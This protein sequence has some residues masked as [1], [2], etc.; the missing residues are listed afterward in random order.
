MLTGMFQEQIRVSDEQPIPSFRKLEVQPPVM[1]MAPAVVVRLPNATIEVSNN[2][3]Q[4]TLEAVLLAL[5]S[6]C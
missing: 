1:G 6:T 3:S 2:A 5:K 4:C